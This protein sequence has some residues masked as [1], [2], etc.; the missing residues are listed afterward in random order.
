M[1]YKQIYSNQE[2]IDAAKKIVTAQLGTGLS[3]SDFVITGI[4]QSEDEIGPGEHDI[5]IT[6]TGTFTLHKALD[7]KDPWWAEME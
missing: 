2:E 1:K 4:M 6:F 5:Q 3:N 7:K